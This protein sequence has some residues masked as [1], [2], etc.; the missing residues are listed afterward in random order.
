MEHVHG[1]IDRVVARRCKLR[2]GDK[3]VTT[4]LHVH[5]HGSRCHVPYVYPCANR[6]LRKRE[7]DRSFFKGPRKGSKVH[8][9]GASWD[10][11]FEICQILSVWEE[12]CA[13]Y[14]SLDKITEPFQVPKT[15]ILFQ[16]PIFIV[17]LQSS[18][19]SGFNSKITESSLFRPP[20]K[21]L[22]PIT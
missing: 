14:F 18:Y 21:I 16:V 2:N 20:S 19:K 4:L 12:A 7:E 15:I 17:L 1:L 5:T 3:S 6:V 13:C 8:W 9:I 22:H 10:G 11:L